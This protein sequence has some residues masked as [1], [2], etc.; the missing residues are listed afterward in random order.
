V[1]AHRGNRCRQ[2][3]GPVP[4][5]GSDA[6]DSGAA[7]RERHS[8]PAQR[9]RR[10]GRGEPVSLPRKPLDTAVAFRTPWFELL[11]KTMDVGGA[12]YYSLRLV[13]Y[14]AVVAITEE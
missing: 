10:D 13:D 2:S 12:P 14:T 5:H 7:A 11:A 1:R 9:F 8:A 4:D 3:A 6:Q